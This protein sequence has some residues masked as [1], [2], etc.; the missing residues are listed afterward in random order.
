MCAH[1][2]QPTLFNRDT[3]THDVPAEEASLADIFSIFISVSMI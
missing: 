3:V 2:E 1:S